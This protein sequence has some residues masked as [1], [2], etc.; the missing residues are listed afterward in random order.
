MNLFHTFAAHCIYFYAMLSRPFS[1]VI[2]SWWVPRR[3][4]ISCL[5]LTSLFALFVI[6]LC[7]L[8]SGAFTIDSSNPT[9]RRNLNENPIQNL[10]VKFCLLIKTSVLLISKRGFLLVVLYCKFLLNVP[11]EY[12]FNNSLLF[13]II[14]LSSC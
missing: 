13:N 1:S 10:I 5:N 11:C 3:S 2:S 14:N 4:R 9:L 8:T 6:L 7:K 12:F